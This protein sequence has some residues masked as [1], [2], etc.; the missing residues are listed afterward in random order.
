MYASYRD[1]PAIGP[2]QVDRIEGRAGHTLRT[3]LSR[4]LAVEDDGGAPPMRLQITLVE[5]VAGYGYRRDESTSLAQLRL[6][7]NYQL[8]PP[9]GGRIMRGSVVTVVDYDIPNSAFAEIAAQDDA[10]ERAAEVMAQRFRAEL[11]MRVA[12][13][14]S[15]TQ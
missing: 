11:A 5:L 12:E 3:E 6:T 7:A 15:Q 4:L 8:T 2:V 9:S 10:R 14:R 13:M 1:G